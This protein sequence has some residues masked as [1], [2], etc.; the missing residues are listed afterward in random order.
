LKLKLYFEVTPSANKISYQSKTIFLGSCFS[1]EISSKFSQAGLNVLSNPFGTIFHPLAILHLFEE[2]EI[3]NTCFQRGDLWFSWMCSG[4]VYALSKEELISK[5]ILKKQEFHDYLIAA[6][7]LFVTFGT[8]IGYRLKST[9]EIVA[10][11]HKMPSTLFDKELTP[12]TDM[13]ST[14]KLLISRL[15]KLNPNL[16]VIFTVSPVRHIKDGIVENNVSKA[17]LFSLIQSIGGVYFPSFEIVN[18][19]LRDYRFF[20]EDLVHPN[21]QAIHYVWTKFCETYLDENTNLIKDEVIAVR[22][23]EQHKTLYPESVESLKFQEQIKRKKESLNSR[24]PNIKW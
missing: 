14:W 17:Q 9:N 20:K 2:V 10:N 3:E 16:N 21:E 5:I 18:D 13:I 4:N 22:K 1:D 23:M 7:F 24:V 15:E 11:C 19:E 12:F 6:D 8:S